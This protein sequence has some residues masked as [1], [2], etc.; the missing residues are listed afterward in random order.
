VSAQQA[1][2]WKGREEEE[3]TLD[4]HR[5]PR[6][7]DDPLTEW[8]G[9]FVF[10]VGAYG[11]THR[12]ITRHLTLW[13]LV[14]LD[15]FYT[16][17]LLGGALLM[18]WGSPWSPFHSHQDTNPAWWARAWLSLRQAFSLMLVAALAWLAIFT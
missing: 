11:T 6:P 13:G 5:S 8:T 4:D 10:A 17:L 3:P 12:P 15:W 14:P 18:L 2:Q 1:V 9:L 16:A 7:W